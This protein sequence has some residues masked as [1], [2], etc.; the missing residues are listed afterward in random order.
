MRAVGS[1]GGRSELP[2]EM[3]RSADGEKY[4]FRW[5]HLESTTKE[6]NE[7]RLEAHSVPQNLR[8]ITDLH[9]LK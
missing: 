9:F 8:R 7:S 5:H 2:M 1:S 4:R 6:T 3:W